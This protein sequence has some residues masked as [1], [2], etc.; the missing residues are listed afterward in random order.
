MAPAP[1]DRAVGLLSWE[2]QQSATRFGLA[3]RF[4][5]AF[6]PK[7]ATPLE[8]CS[9]EIEPGRLIF[10]APADRE[11]LMGETPRKR[12]ASLAASFEAEPVEI[13]EA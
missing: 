1:D 13:F 5:A 11:V 9:L 4:L 6:S 2:A 10:R 12:F 8:D 7:V 3:M